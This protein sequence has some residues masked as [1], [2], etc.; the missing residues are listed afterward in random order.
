[1]N[2]SLLINDL[3]NVLEGANKQNAMT[4]DEILNSKLEN[5]PIIKK[6]GN[7]LNKS[8]EDFII[9]N[10]ELTKNL[11]DAVKTREE[12]DKIT[13]PDTPTVDKPATSDKPATP[14]KP[15][16]KDDEDEDD[17][18]E[19]IM[20]KFKWVLIGIGIFVFLIICGGLIYYYYS[21]SPAEPEIN[22]LNN[23]PAY[24]Y[25]QEPYVRSA[26]TPEALPAQSS[27]F[28]FSAHPQAPPVQ[29]APPVDQEYSYMMPF[30]FSQNSKEQIDNLQDTVRGSVKKIS[31]KEEP[32]IQE[33]AKEEAV[34]QEPAKEEPVIQ[35]P[36]KEE[37]VN[38][39]E[40]TGS[41]S[42]SE[43]EEKNEKVEEKSSS[44]SSSDNSDD[45]SEEKNEKAED[46]SGKDSKSKKKDNEEDN[47]IIGGYRGSGRGRGRGR[48]NGRV[49]EGARNN[50]KN[51]DTGFN[52]I[53]NKIFNSVK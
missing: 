34:I 39:D 38:E 24:Q 42:D 21:S 19:G 40:D 5:N 4:K 7:I 12:Q 16:K 45:E 49:R 41:S 50:A 47:K 2:S 6:L 26:P 28:S 8:F 9:D 27:L 44:E 35:K 25:N 48:G 31:V 14:D 18:D 20:G 23:N 52:Y 11:N 10:N 37:P 1:M 22:V 32:V 53:I 17:E 36:A 51:K 33:P 3:I 46:T 13:S 29:Q 30:S 43:S 15:E